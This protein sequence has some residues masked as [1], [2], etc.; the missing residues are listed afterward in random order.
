[1]PTNIFIKTRRLL[2]SCVKVKNKTKN[3]QKKTNLFKITVNT[4]KLL[5]AF[6]PCGSYMLKMMVQILLQ[7]SIA[8]INSSEVLSFYKRWLNTV[9]LCLARRYKDIKTVS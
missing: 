4:I 5:L 6:I 8:A 3:K 1:M 2:K 9:F 7:F